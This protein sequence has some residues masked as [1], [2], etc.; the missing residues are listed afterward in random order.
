MQKKPKLPYD[1]DYQEVDAFPA[2]WG[3]C[4]FLVRYAVGLT[5]REKSILRLSRSGLSYYRIGRT[6]KCDPTNVMW[7]HQN[8]LRKFTQADADLAFASEI[9][10][11][12]SLEK[13]QK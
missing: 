7:S 5:E 12:T 4:A 11:L 8:A 1:F 9:G 13:K 10:L 6:I 3:V 2:F